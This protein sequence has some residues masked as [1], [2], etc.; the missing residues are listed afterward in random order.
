MRLTQQCEVNFKEKFNEINLIFHYGFSA[1]III[2]VFIPGR[3]HLQLDLDQRLFRYLA[4]RARCL[5][6]VVYL[7]LC[8][9]GSLAAACLPISLRRGVSQSYKIR[10]RDLLGLQVNI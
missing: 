3:E 9:G 2:S 1:A 5:S 4:L 8:H 7:C 10:Q 6:I